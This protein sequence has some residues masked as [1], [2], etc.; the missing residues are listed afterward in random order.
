MNIKD[1]LPK[2]LPFLK[3][4]DSQEF[5]FALNIGS[6][7]LS[8]SVWGLSG[9]TLQLINVAEVKVK[10]DDDLVE[11]AN[12]AL[13]EALQDFQPEPEKI[14]FGVPDSWMLDDN[15]KETHLN[16]LKHLV[17]ELDV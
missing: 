2:N 14:L 10:G 4:S 1:L 15:L 9:R 13:D 12:T 8:A 6:D 17:K 3:G 16:F 11:A 7:T 5:Y